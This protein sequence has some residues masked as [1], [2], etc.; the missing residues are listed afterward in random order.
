MGDLVRFGGRRSFTVMALVLVAGWS[1]AAR[2]QAAAHAKGDISGDWQGLA[3]GEREV[4]RISKLDDGG[5]QTLVYQIDQSGM[6]QVVPL[7]MLQ[8]DALKFDF[9]FQGPSRTRF[10]GRVSADG[11]TISGTWKEGDRA[12]VKVEFVRATKETAWTIPAPPKGP[13]M[14]AAD[15]D[16]SFAVATIK[17]T[18]LHAGQA[19]IETAP[20]MR[21]MARMLNTPGNRMMFRADGRRF[22]EEGATLAQ[23][24]TFAYDLHA[25]Q[26]EGGPEWVTKEQYDISAEEDGDGLP[27]TDQWR[28]MMRKLLAERFGLTVRHEKKEL[29]VYVL[30]VEKP[31]MLKAAQQGEIGMMIQKMMPGKITVTAIDMTMADFATRTIG[32]I[33]KDRPMVDSTGL[34]GRYDISL[35]YARDSDLRDGEGGGAAKA[36]DPSAPDFV[37]ALKEQLGLKVEAVK[38]PV[39]V[40]VIEQVT[41]PTEN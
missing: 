39:D 3:G 15:A 5:W 9:G 6:P 19:Q 33:L 23:M 16:P 27:T 40:V 30:S 10:D 14:L 24:I 11:N 31:G 21:V 2:A 7:T 32:G 28:L 34:A 8:G 36:N 17:P 12:A 37:S 41:R 20:G 22:S 4:L 26:V 38:A 13:K 25:K 18:D 1:A 35:T 29:P